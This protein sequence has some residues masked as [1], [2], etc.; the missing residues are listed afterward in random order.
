MRER[1]RE[2]ERESNIW[3]QRRL[4]TKPPKRVEL[5]L[6]QS[7]GE[8]TAIISLMVSFFFFKENEIRDYFYEMSCMN[9]ES[10]WLGVFLFFVEYF[11]HWKISTIKIFVNISSKK[12]FMANL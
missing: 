2:R 1:E 8:F 7:H 9:Y 12:V 3:Y 4:Y 6:L 11:I 5:L 10:K